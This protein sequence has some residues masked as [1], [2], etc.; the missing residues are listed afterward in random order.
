MKSIQSSFA[1]ALAALLFCIVA[2]PSVRAETW[3]ARPITMVFGFG[4]GSSGDTVARVLA[5]LRQRNWASAGSSKAGQAPA[6]LR[7]LMDGRKN[8]WQARRFGAYSPPPAITARVCS[9]GPNSSALSIDI[10]SASR[11]RARL[12]RD[13]MVPTA[14]PQMWAASS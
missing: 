10:S 6:A 11:V 2:G 14:Q 13:L 1:R 3:P 4:A 12:T 5:D 7:Q 8:S 9:S